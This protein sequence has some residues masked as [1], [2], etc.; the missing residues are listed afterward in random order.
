VTPG[1]T[2]LLVLIGNDALASVFRGSGVALLQGVAALIVCPAGQ[3][4]SPYE[5]RVKA[6]V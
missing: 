6:A 4:T 5:R 1:E 3:L 2:A